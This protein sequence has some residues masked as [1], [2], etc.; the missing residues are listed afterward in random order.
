MQAQICLDNNVPSDELASF[1][2]QIE[3]RLVALSGQEGELRSF[4]LPA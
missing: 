2:A 1:K 3:A 4:E